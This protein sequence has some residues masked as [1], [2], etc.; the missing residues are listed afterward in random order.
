[1]LDAV[2]S[3]DGHLVEVARNYGAGFRALVVE[4]YFPAALP[5]L[6]T[7]FRLAATRCFVTAI[8]VELLSGPDGIGTLIWKSWQTFSTERL[9]VGIATSAIVGIVIYQGLAALESRLTPWRADNA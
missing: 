8:A 3:T 5:Q 4:I 2:R 9:Y 7:A 6:F 1:M